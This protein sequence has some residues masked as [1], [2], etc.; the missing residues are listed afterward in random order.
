M[1]WSIVGCYG[2]R[3]M[4]TPRG[5]TTYQKDHA[6]V[7]NSWLGVLPDCAGSLAPGATL[8][9]TLSM[10]GITRAGVHTHTLTVE[11]ST[12]NAARRALAPRP[13]LPSFLVLAGACLGCLRARTWVLT[14]P[15]ARRRAQIRV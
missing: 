3:Y 11:T 4:S 9:L 13:I 15:S 2:N 12:S 5:V 1:Y 8:N 10:A 14:S 6:G 7:V